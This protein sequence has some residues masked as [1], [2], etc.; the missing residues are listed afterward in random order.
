[1][2]TAL[3]ETATDLY[4]FKWPEKVALLVGNE[5]AGLS[6]TAL[7]MCDSLIYI[8]MRGFVQSLNVSVATALCIG[9]LTRSRNK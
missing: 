4:K 5:H 2:G 1:M 7:K 3:N 8:P 9:E 6:E